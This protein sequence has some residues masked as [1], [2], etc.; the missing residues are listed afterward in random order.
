VVSHAGVGLLQ[1]MAEYSG[2]VDEITEALIG[3]YRGVP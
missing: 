3:T 1:E 2:L